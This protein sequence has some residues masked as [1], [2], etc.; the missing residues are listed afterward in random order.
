MAGVPVQDLAY[1]GVVAGGASGVNQGVPGAQAE[2]DPF[3][4]EGRRGLGHPFEQPPRVPRTV[5]PQV[6]ARKLPTPGTGPYPR[7]CQTEDAAV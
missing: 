6:K 1:S 3:R 7:S 5:F 4:A 2:E